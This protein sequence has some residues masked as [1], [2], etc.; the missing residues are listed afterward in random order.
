MAIEDVRHALAPQA[1]TQILQEA[2]DVCDESVTD[3]IT[4]V[5][6]PHAMNIQ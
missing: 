5:S 6:D 3:A 1:L 2:M 4:T